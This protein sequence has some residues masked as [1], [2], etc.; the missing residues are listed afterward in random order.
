MPQ[1]DD[2][3]RY[4]IPNAMLHANTLRKSVIDSFITFNFKDFITGNPAYIYP[5]SLIFYLSDDSQEVAR[6][7][8]LIFGIMSIFVLFKLT[9]DLYNTR[10]AN[11]TALLLAFSPNYMLLSVAIL[12]DTHSIFFLLW[13]F[14]LWRLYQKTPTIK[15]KFL[16]VF[17]FL[18]LGMLRPPVMLVLLC[19]VILHKTVFQ[20]KKNKLLVARIIQFGVILGI[21]LGTFI[22]LYSGS[23][24]SD[25]RIIKGA[26]YIDI[27]NMIKRSDSTSDADSGYT[28]EFRYT[29]IYEAILFMPILVIYFMGS[30]F[31]WMVKKTNQALAMADSSVLWFLYIYFFLEIKAFYKRDRKWALIIFSYILIGVC[32]A[33]LVQGNM[34]GAL[35]H[36][37][38]FTALMFPFAANNI[39]NRFASRKWNNKLIMKS[40]QN[41]VK[42]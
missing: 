32:S 37:L 9:E 4:Y 3:F 18:Y 28:G 40:R 39:L 19:V 38:L 29:N 30:P 35:R 31:P 36:R 10:T 15:V 8:S 33:S 23:V 34:G 14:R 24:L 12:R 2:T 1:N 6:L 21:L 11:F 42:I 22:N 27:D 7:F 16:M 20:Y 5:L 17:S 13:F 26:E 41:M 25:L